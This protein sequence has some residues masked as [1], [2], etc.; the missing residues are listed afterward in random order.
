MALILGKG[1]ERRQCLPGVR[2][3]DA[4]SGYLPSS[5]FASCCYR[6]L[7]ADSGDADRLP[8]VLMGF[9]W[10][11]SL[12][13]QL[14]ALPLA[15]V[16]PLLAIFAQGVAIWLFAG[17]AVCSRL[18][19][20][21]AT[22]GRRGVML[23]AVGLSTAAR[24]ALCRPRALPDR[25]GQRHGAPRTCPMAP[26][27]K[28]NLLDVVVPRI[29]ARRDPMPVLIHL[30]GGAWATGDKNQQGKPLLHHMAARGWL[31]FDATYRLG[32]GRSRA[33]LDRRCAARDRLGARARR[34][35]WR[36]SR[37][38]SPS[39]ADRRADIWP[40]SPRCPRRSRVQARVRERRLFGRRGGAA[41]RPLRF[42]RPQADRLKGN[43][44]AVIDKFMA[45]KVMPGSPDSC[46]NCGMRSARSTGCAADAPPMLI[47]H[48]TG[49]TMLPWQDARTSPSNLRAVSRA[50]RSVRRAARHP[51]RLGH[52]RSALTWGH[53][54]AVAAFLAPLETPGQ[55]FGPAFARGLR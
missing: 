34:R 28:R 30:H 36:R 42:S 23:D 29:R 17:G 45:A 3:R 22:G 55:A 5:G 53:V 2:S 43:H 26:R 12:M 40:R 33:G 32:P 20:T 54:R 38:G 15:I 44:A 16:T 47:V 21:G 19:S 13:G 31:C 48:G 27:G 14:F 25:R 49:D 7:R 24:A 18:W 51:A 1:L 46:P 8:A 11:A 50:R 39:P 6:G 37:H 52:G 35:A 41:L 10:M 9:Y 4:P